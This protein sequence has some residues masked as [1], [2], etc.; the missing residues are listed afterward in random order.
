MVIL[1][2]GGT[3]IAALLNVNGFSLSIS[4]EN[5]SN[6]RPSGRG[7]M[8][9]GTPPAKWM[10]AGGGLNGGGISKLISK[11]AKLVTPPSIC[12]VVLSI[13][14][15]K[16]LFN[17]PL[18]W[19]AVLIGSPSTRADDLLGAWLNPVKS[20]KSSSMSANLRI[21][22]TIVLVLYYTI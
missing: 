3:L 10:L 1:L 5:S 13:G 15:W 20:P 16:S 2:E 8:S 21:T 4:G 12:E 7:G 17:V 9:N 19:T 14:S 18:L 22:A 11:C 6:E